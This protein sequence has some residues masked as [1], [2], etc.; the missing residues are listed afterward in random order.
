MVL[1][2]PASLYSDTSACLTYLNNLPRCTEGD[3]QREPQLFHCYWSGAVGAKQALSIKSCLATQNCRLYLWL[4][5]ANGYDY[6]KENAQLKA[7]LPRITVRSYDP[8]EEAAGT[9]FEGSPLL[10][11]Q[12]LAHRSDVFR[13]LILY[14]FGGY[15]FDLDVLFLRDLS[16]LWCLTGGAEFCYRWSYK[17]FGNSAILKL[18][19]SSETSRHLVAKALSRGTC[20]PWRLFTPD[21]ME[22]NLLMLPSPFFDPLWLINDRADTLEASPLRSFADFFQP[23]D[24]R[25]LD[26]R[27]RRVRAQFNGCFTYH[28]HNQWT[29]PEVATSLAAAFN[30]LVD[31]ALIQQHG[32]S[33]FPSFQVRL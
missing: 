29:A 28:W 30:R 2:T 12:A 26:E 4:D 21:D 6:Y 33:P 10:D 23:N 13:I 11:E 24:E 7:L 3:A 5:R 14:K 25:T 1:L 22:L 16:E 19:S 9:P 20:L 15:Y 31:D 32:L 8:F 18:N 17:P 27:M